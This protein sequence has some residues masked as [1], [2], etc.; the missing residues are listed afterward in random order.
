MASDG[1]VEDSPA[2]TR[3]QEVVPEHLMV[4]AAYAST[5]V[6]GRLGGAHSD[7]NIDRND[8]VHDECRLPAAD[9]RRRAP[10]DALAA[11]LFLCG[12]TADGRECVCYPPTTPLDRWEMD[13][14]GAANAAGSSL[15]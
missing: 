11:F 2:H 7:T 1:I 10:A 12:R 15:V 14:S 3:T 13:E 9:L 5:D 4:I 8:C 6:D